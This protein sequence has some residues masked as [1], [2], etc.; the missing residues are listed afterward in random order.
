MR[1][2]SLST[3]GG[4]PFSADR[5]DDLQ[6]AHRGVLLALCQSL[7]PVGENRAYILSGLTE[8][9]VGTVHTLTSGWVYVPEQFAEPVYY[10]GG[11]MD[12]GGGGDSL[13][14]TIVSNN[15][16]GAFY[17]GVVRNVYTDYTLQLTH[18]ASSPYTGGG[19]PFNY[20]S[21]VRADAESWTYVTGSIVT[22]N[23][24]YG[25]YYRKDRFSHRVDIRLS[26]SSGTPS[27][28]TAISS[29]GDSIAVFTLPAGMR[30]SAI[31]LFSVPL[32]SGAGNNYVYE[33]SGWFAST[34][35][36]V[37][38]DGVVTIQMFKPDASVANYSAF[39]TISVPI[40]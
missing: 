27:G 25:C 28:L 34:N 8:T 26:I 40:G 37:G 18:G 2:L 16:T 13:L 5:L 36:M 9:V 11:S 35:V 1:K 20:S 15:A 4:Y 10:A 23:I 39:G 14:V 12:V 7:F 24:T 21:F 30:P 29:G 31:Q 17:D 22:G 38:T 6:T 3:A 33:S 19:G 32:R